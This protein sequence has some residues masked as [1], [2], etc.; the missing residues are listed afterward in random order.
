M[1]DI[2][3]ELLSCYLPENTLEYFEVKKFK[4]DDSHLIIELEERNIL[5]IIPKEHRGKRVISKGFR[6]ISIN[7]FTARGRKVILIFFRRVWKIE[8]VHS[9]LKKDISLKAKGTKLN[10][11]FAD[12]LKE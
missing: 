12:F 5:P 2:Y 11:E 1:T 3:K 7:D 6:K 10:K 8:G 4:K 9:L